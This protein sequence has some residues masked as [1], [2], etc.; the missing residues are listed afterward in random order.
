M[1]FIKNCIAIGVLI[2]PFFS[3]AST[4]PTPEEVQGSINA[5]A[6]GRSVEVVGEINLSFEKLFSGGVQGEGKLSDLG[7]IIASIE[8]DKLK[9]EVYKIYMNCI[10]P[11]LKVGMSNKTPKASTNSNNQKSSGSNSPNFNISNGSSAT[12]IISN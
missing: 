1:L 7:G 11:M 4:L 5:C 3:Y 8:D 9:V 10:M 6:A 12:V 2:T